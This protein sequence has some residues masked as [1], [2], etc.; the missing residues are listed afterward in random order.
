M[1]NI[2]K[3]FLALIVLLVFFSLN[4][5]TQDEPLKEKYQAIILDSIAVTVSPNF[6][7][8]PGDTVTQSEFSID[9]HPHNE[10]IV[11]FSANATTWPPSSGHVKLYGAGVYWS[12]DGGA[13]WMGFDN[14]PFE[15]DTTET[16]PAVAIDTNGYFYTNF[17]DSPPNSGGQGIAVSK[18]SGNTWTRYE[19]A[20]TTVY[21]AYDKNHLTIDKSLSSQ[22]NNRLYRSLTDHTSLSFATD[23]GNGDWEVVKYEG[24]QGR[25]GDQG[26]SGLNGAT[27]ATGASGAN[28]G[29]GVDG[30]FAAKASQAEAQAGNT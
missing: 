7:P 26:P 3:V 6:R 5:F 4:L 24:I 14:P 30:I 17:M 18:D 1:K 20:A 23:F 29:A 15:Y 8:W 27:G 25:T 12:L 22:Y 2:L 19:V 28:G 16:D 9:V 13:N 21:G 11:F 10:N